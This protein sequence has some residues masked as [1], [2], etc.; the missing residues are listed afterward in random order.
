MAEKM[1]GCGLE[2]DDLM[3]ESNLGLIR[4]L[5]TFDPGRGNRFVTYAGM[6]CWQRMSRSIADQA[7]LIRFPVHIRELH[8]KL[9]LLVEQ[10]PLGNYEPSYEELASSLEVSPEVI[11][12]LMFVR[13]ISS[14][15]DECMDIAE[16]GEPAALRNLY[17]EDLARLIH[18]ML[19]ELPER[20]ADVIRKR[21]GIDEPMEH[22]L[23]E[24]GQIYGVTRERIRQIEAKVMTQFSNPGR[25][26]PLRAFLES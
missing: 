21:F 5:E 13:N 1:C 12:R 14:L 23:E 4:A 2:F 15:T 25:S 6:W 20:Q 16:D 22:T 18:A 17:A 11:R 24:V 7:D 9:M 10:R 19:D 26:R 3:Q 8:S